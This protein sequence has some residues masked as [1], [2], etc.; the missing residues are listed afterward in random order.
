MKF[1]KHIV[2]M[3]LALAIFPVFVHGAGI[4]PCGNNK[5]DSGG[6]LTTTTPD[7]FCEFKDLVT[8]AS[9]IITRVIEVAV[10]LSAI[11]F[12]YAGFLYMTA[13]GASEK[14][15]AAHAIFK[16]ALTGL[17]IM[18]SAYLIIHTILQAL[19]PTYEKVPTSTTSPYA[20]KT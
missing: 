8:L 18:L 15:S 7:R 6:K 3:L 19:A 10:A 4:V 12:A 9:T 1:S 5:I 17:I 11:T 13:G 16:T 2:I 14:I 20:P